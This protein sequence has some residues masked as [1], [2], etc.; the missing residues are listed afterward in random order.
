M[1]VMVKTSAGSAKSSGMPASAVVNAAA[2]RNRR[3]LPDLPRTTGRGAI[4]RLHRRA[5]MGATANTSRKLMRKRDDAAG[6][7]SDQLASWLARAFPAAH[8]LR[9]SSYD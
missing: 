6:E 3:A 1:L 7:P 4:R 9:R 5:L 8:G 2:A